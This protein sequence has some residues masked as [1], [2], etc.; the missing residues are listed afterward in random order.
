V[1]RHHHTPA[2]AAVALTKAMAI[3]TGKK[4]LNG[5]IPVIL[6]AG[7]FVLNGLLRW[8]LVVTLAIVAPLAI[9]WAWP[10]NRET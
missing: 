9:I 8:P 5:V 1:E 10:R 2:P 4:C 6:F 3:Q 7:T